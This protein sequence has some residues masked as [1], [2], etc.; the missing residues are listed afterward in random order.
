[1]TKNI[2]LYLIFISTLGA[3]TACGQ[4]S[5]PSSNAPDTAATN[6]SNPASG[7][8]L[9]STPIIAPP[10]YDQ[11]P[12]KPGQTQQADTLPNGLPALKPL[13]GVNVDKLFSENISNTDRRFDR[14]ENAVVDLRREFEIAKPA[15]V[16]LVAVEEDIQTLVEQLELLANEEAKRPAQALQPATPTTVSPATASNAPTTLKPP[17]TT[18]PPKPAA[19]QQ[20]AAGATTVKNLRIGQHKDKIRV[21]LDASRKTAYSFELDN[22]EKFLLIEMPD[23]AWQGAKSKTFSSKT[24][25]LKSYEVESINGGK[26]SRIVVA[27]KQQTTLLKQQA[28]PPGSVSPNYRI[29]VDLKR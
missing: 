19:P 13:K 9:P 15:I 11:R 29:F 10:S 6:A 23:A 4:L 24:P 16:R 3:L 28:I 8:S 21:V 12:L 18:K 5:L 7:K 22:G 27:L 17:T 25:I 26:G 20:S 2:G 14:V 1:M